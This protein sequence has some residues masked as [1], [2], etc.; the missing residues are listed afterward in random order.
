MLLLCEKTV[1]NIKRK[2]SQ[3]KNLGVSDCVRVT[4]QTNLLA[5]GLFL[6]LVAGCGHTT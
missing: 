6:L 4:R 1:L 2:S 5:Q 3:G